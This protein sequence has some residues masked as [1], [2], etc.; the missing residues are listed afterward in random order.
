MCSMPAPSQRDQEDA[1][2]AERE[3]PGQRHLRD[4][5]GDRLEVVTRQDHR[6]FLQRHGSM[7][8][9]VSHE[10]SARRRWCVA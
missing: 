6:R 2:P 4:G 7:D 10:R 8:V 1:D 3:P 5:L 9:G